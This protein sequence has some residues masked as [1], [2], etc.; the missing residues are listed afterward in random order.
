[1]RIFVRKISKLGPLKY[2][3]IGITLVSL[4]A[5]VGLMAV[6]TMVDISLW[7]NPVVLLVFLGG[8]LFFGSVAY[9]FGI[10]PYFI[11]RSLPEVLVEADGEFLYI[12]NRKEAKIALC[13]IDEVTVDVDLPYSLV[14]DRFW[15]E[16]ILHLC[17]ERYGTVILEI[18]GHGKFKIRF[19]ANAQEAGD[20]L[21]DFLKNVVEGESTSYYGEKVDLFI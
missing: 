21:F 13:D 3:M 15:E 10:R 20:S 18:P 9:F 14:Q 7:L 4:A 2:R 12:H 1:M 11:Y 5:T 16:L 17:S 8:M 6:F 19:A